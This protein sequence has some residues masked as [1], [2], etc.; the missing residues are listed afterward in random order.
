M[1]VKLQEGQAAPDFAL[2]GSDGQQHSLKD[3][4][5]QRLL[6]Y[7]YPRDNT[8]GCTVEAKNFATGFAEYETRKV[9]VL[10]ISTDSEKSHE[11]FSTKL[12]L[13]FP[14]LADSEGK[15]AK[16]YGVLK[17]LRPLIMTARRVSFL[18]DPK[19]NIE[20]IWDPVKAKTHHEEVLAY[21]D[22]N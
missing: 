18:I 1:P 21:L 12:C 3:Y 4:K 14:L 2:P 11:K 13:P 19:G 15:M 22:G 8:P 5:G 7:F 10:G 20:K 6:L 9:A 16:A 17:S